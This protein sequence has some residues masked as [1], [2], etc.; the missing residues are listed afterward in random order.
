[1]NFLSIVLVLFRG[2][3]L[4]KEIHSWVFEGSLFLT[5][6]S[7][8]WRHNGDNN[9][10]THQDSIPKQKRPS[11]YFFKMSLYHWGG[12]KWW[13]WFRM[14]FVCGLGVVRDDCQVL[15][16]SKYVLRDC[17]KKNCVFL[18]LN[19]LIYIQIY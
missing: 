5:G 4:L 7:N 2:C 6:Y 11:K 13:G 17:L 1:M 8:P 15:T 10:M 14:S 18:K 16:R 3:F 19:Y 9:S 12:A